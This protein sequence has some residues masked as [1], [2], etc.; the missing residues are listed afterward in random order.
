M[1]LAPLCGYLSLGGNGHEEAQESQNEE[2]SVWGCPATDRTLSDLIDSFLPFVRRLGSLVS[3]V[4]F[5]GHLRFGGLATKRLKSH[6][7]KEG[8]SGDVRLPIG[9]GPCCSIHLFPSFGGSVPLC[10]LRLF[11]AMSAPEEMATKR[12]KS[13]KMDGVASRVLAAHRS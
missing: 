8:L 2:G 6:K 9:R 12:H 11:A 7:M 10:L 3:L 13:R 1:S 5:R 4:P